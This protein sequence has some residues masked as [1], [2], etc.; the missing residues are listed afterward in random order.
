MIP[1]SIF[2]VEFILYPALEDIIINPINK[3]IVHVIW[4][5]KMSLAILLISLTLSFLEIQIIRG[6]R[7]PNKGNNIKLRAD[8][9]R[10]VRSPLSS[11]SAQSSISSGATPNV[12][13]IL[14]RELPLGSVSPFSTLWIVRKLNLAFSDNSSCEKPSC[15][16]AL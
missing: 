16:L 12:A 1:A 7:I 6:I 5:F 14:L 3:T 15:F 13:P 2:P 8:R 4:K 10:L 9:F 11:Y